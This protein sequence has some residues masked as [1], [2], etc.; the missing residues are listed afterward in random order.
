[1]KKQIGI[2]V[3]LWFCASFMSKAQSTQPEVVHSIVKICKEQKWYI[4]QY[5]LWKKALA[6]KANNPTGWLNYYTAARMA[7]IMAPNEEE[8]NQ[9]Y[10]KM[11][12]IVEEMK[13]HIKGSYEYHYIQSYHKTD[14]FEGIDHALAAYKL[15]PN[16]PEVYDELMTHY[17][18]TRNKA[19]LKEIAKKWKASGDLSP[20]I[21]I[22]NY[23]TLHST[24][25]NAILIT[26]GDNDTYPSLIL[27]YADN[28][29]TDVTVVNRS[30]V[31]N[32]TYRKALFE[33]LNIPVLAGEIEDPKKITEHIIKHRGERPV[34]F[35]LGGNPARLGMEGKLY[36]VGLALKYSEDGTNTTSLLIKNFEN[37]I[38]LDHL[39]C[40]LY[41]E[42]FPTEMHKYNVFYV[43]GLLMLYKHYLISNNV[44]K[45][46]STRELIVKIGKNYDQK[47][48]VLGVLAE[49]ESKFKS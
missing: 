48:E 28:E 19:K 40:S 21:L 15:D 26:I 18:L 22:W 9:W 2:I 47:E 10:E 29:R 34:Y 37:N 13:P 12:T 30:L 43:P 27:Q 39:K 7:K 45:Q 41:T 6:K 44:S 11:G 24:E 5:E 38:L 42:A 46:A 16:R 14:H 23:N 20:T 8:R 3:L 4:E 49:Y 36:N 25:K 32:E 35:A 1:M 17:E 31:L 33:E